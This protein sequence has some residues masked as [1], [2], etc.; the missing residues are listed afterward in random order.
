MFWPLLI[1]FGC[2][3]L[4]AWMTYTPWF[5]DSD[6]Y[7]L[8]FVLV[9]VLMAIVW[10]YASRS[11]T[12][13]GI[14]TLSAICDAA[15]IL[16]YYVLPILAFGVRVNGLTVLGVVLIVAGAVSVKFGESP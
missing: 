7:P 10:V 5:R 6:R 14:L 12:Q 3:L 8:A 2:Y 11:T 15:M 13:R 4:G 9:S 16:A 1:I